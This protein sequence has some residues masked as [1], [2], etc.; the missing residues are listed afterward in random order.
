MTQAD[1][2]SEEKHRGSPNISGD[3]SQFKDI[4]A[5]PSAI[6]EYPEGGAQGWL[7]AAGAAGVLF[8]TM[9]YT[10]SFGI[11]ESYYREN[12]LRDESTAKIACIGSLQAF[13]MFSAGSVGGPLF[14]RYGAFVS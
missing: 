8:S 3:V 7:V 6:D 14:D 4:E 1:T 11:F 10:N 5:A 13:L 9:A 12:Q 2:V